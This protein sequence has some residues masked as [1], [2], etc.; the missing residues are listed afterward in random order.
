MLDDVSFSGR[1]TAGE[2][3]RI[4][5]ESVLSTDLLMLALVRIAALYARATISGYS[6]GA[7]AQGT[8]SGN[9]YLGANIEFPGE[10]L[11]FCLHAEQAATVNAWVHGEQDVTA[12]AV[13]AAPCGFCRQFLS[14]L[15]DAGSL[16]LVLPG[17]TTTLGVLLPHP[18][19]PSAIGTFKT[20]LLHPADHGLTLN[21]SADDPVVR[22]ALDSANMSYAPYTRSYAGV[23][24]QSPSGRIVAGPYAE[25][26][27]YNPSLSPMAAAVSRLN[28]STGALEIARAVLV[29]A[30]TNPARSDQT[31]ASLAMLKALAPSVAL[32]SYTARP[33]GS[34]PSTVQP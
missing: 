32:E 18:F 28:H 16:R 31:A 23:A 26:A 7:V 34:P 11:A 19:G 1:L 22:Q 9:L 24:L 20:R 13:S 27:A 29:Q 33:S 30:A 21:A 3:K 17:R 2:S 10:A 25:N 5:E 15:G 8:T 14:D 4:C 6:V 12:L